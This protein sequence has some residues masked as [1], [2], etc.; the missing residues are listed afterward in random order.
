MSLVLGSRRSTAALKRL[1]NR[2][3]R[4]TG[5]FV[6]GRKHVSTCQRFMR[7]NLLS[8]R[9]KTM[10]P[11]IVTPVLSHRI[12]QHTRCYAVNVVLCPRESLITAK[13]AAALISFREQ[14]RS[15]RRREPLAPL[16]RNSTLFN[17]LVEQHC[18]SSAF[19]HILVY[20]KQSA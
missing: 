10:S 18:S 13:T 9:L 4:K 8:R 12:R 19:P 14:L 1:V 5:K 15:F 3:K 20:P 2:W 6:A 17:G 11:R 16:P 7:S